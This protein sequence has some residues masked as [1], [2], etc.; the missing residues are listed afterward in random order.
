MV[1]AEIRQKQTKGIPGTYQPSISVVK[2]GSRSAPKG[3]MSRPIKEEVE[4]A[5]KPNGEDVPKSVGSLL[6]GR[7]RVVARINP[8]IPNSNID[9]QKDK[10]LDHDSIW[11]VVVVDVVVT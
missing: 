4:N 5:I 8:V 7:L 2:R 1:Q 11:L 6:L 3:R 9:G 10:R